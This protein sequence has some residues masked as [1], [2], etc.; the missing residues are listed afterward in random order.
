MQN[1]SYKGHISAFHLY[2]VQ[3]TLMT[4]PRNAWTSRGL[5]FSPFDER[6][7]FF[8]LPRVTTGWLTAR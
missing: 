3:I 8:W 4:L 5:S 7:L 1:M 2:S 6:P